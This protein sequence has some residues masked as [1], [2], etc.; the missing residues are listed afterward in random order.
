MVFLKAI[1]GQ[2]DMLRT[3]ILLNSLAPWKGKE[4]K[5]RLENLVF[6]GVL[7][8]L[9]SLSENVLMTGLL[10]GFLHLIVCLVQDFKLEFKQSLDQFLYLNLLPIDMLHMKQNYSILLF[11]FQKICPVKVEKC[12]K[13]GRFTPPP[14]LP[15]KG[16]GVLFERGISIYRGCP[17]YGMDSVSEEG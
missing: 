8:G 5:R 15:N 4:L 6:S 16:G 7:F 1:L 11:V 10:S 12:Q 13:T 3:F 9:S 17:N 2:P 14:H